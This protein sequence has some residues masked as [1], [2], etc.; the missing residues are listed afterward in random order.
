M[1]GLVYLNNNVVKI[2]LP[3]KFVCVRSGLDNPSAEDS[4]YHVYNFLKSTQQILA[5]LITTQEI[6]LLQAYYVQNFE[7]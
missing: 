3:R 7:C 6:T 1:Y 4:A 5:T 2:E